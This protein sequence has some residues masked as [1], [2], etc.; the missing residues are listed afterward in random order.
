[1]L[2][3]ISSFSECGAKFV[4]RI[5]VTPPFRKHVVRDQDVLLFS[6]SVCCTYSVRAVGKC[7]WMSNWLLYHLNTVFL[8]S[9]GIELGSSIVVNLDYYHSGKL[10]KYWREYVTI[11]LLKSKE[12]S[13]STNCASSEILAPYDDALNSQCAE[14]CVVC[15][16]SQFLS[17]GK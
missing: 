11:I 1:M 10:T 8:L 4:V 7:C 17:K 2:S 14:A 13:S 9:V 3:W 6:C 16:L 5:M 15:G 12:F